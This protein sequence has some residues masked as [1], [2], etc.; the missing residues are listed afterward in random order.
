M[1][2]ACPVHFFVGILDTNVGFMIRA[3]LDLSHDC[4]WFFLVFSWRVLAAFRFRFHGV[5]YIKAKPLRDLFIYL[6]M[7]CLDNM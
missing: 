4:L 3:T 6:V 2:F 5:H 7:P 1:I